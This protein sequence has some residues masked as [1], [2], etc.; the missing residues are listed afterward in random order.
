MSVVELAPPG[1]ET[2]LSRGEFTEETKGQKAMEV[3]VLVK[4]AIAG[5]EASKTEIRPGLS[6]VLKTMSRI[7]P[8][9]TLTQIA[10]ASRP[11]SNPNLVIALPDGSRL[12]TFKADSDKT[13]LP[14][15]VLPAM[16]QQ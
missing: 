2:P 9:F 4:A 16:S 12:V 6:N 11:K 10:N 8:A 3:V 5:I 15:A 14:Q 13:G 1:V 7:A